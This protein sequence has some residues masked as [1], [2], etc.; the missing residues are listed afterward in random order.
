MRL[1]GVEY[2]APALFALW[3]FGFEV[4]SFRAVGPPRHGF[5]PALTDS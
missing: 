1:A 4:L 2:V 3:A 5:W